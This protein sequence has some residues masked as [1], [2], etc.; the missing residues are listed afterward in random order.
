MLAEIDAANSARDRDIPRTK[1]Y[2]PILEG[3]KL[4]ALRLALFSWSLTPM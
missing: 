4:K 1:K 2:L 3:Y